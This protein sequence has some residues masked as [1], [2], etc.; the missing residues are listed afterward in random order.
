MYVTLKKRETWIDRQTHLSLSFIAQGLIYIT[1]CL[2]IIRSGSFQTANCILHGNCVFVY[3]SWQAKNVQERGHG[4]RDSSKHHIW[5]EE[6]GY[7]KFLAIGSGN[8]LHLLTLSLTPMLY[9][10]TSI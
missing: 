6:T 2:S 10:Q 8:I 4:D 3:K 9:G 5:F 1:H 7:I